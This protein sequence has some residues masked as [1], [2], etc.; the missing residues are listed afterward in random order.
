MAQAR[1]RIF[2]FWALATLFLLGGLPASQPAYAFDR[3]GWS[4]VSREEIED[5][6]RTL[7]RA[8]LLDADQIDGLVGSITGQAILT[9]RQ[10]AG[11]PGGYEPLSP[12][13]RAL[14]EAYADGR[15][16]MGLPFGKVQPSR[17]ELELIRSLVR[18][19][20]ASPKE[21]Q[22][23][24]RPVAAGNL[25]PVPCDIDLDLLAQD[26]KAVLVLDAARVGQDG[27]DTLREIDWIPVKRSGRIGPGTLMSAIQ[28]DTDADLDNLRSAIRLAMGEFAKYVF[29]E[30][31]LE[32]MFPNRHLY[33]TETPPGPCRFNEVMAFWPRGLHDFAEDQLS[34]G[35][36]V[37]LND[38]TERANAAE[39][40]NERAAAAL[41]TAGTVRGDIEAAL[42]SYLV[43]SDVTQ[44]RPRALG[45]RAYLSAVVVSE[46]WFD[47]DAMTEAELA[48]RELEAV[49][50]YLSRAFADGRLF[51]DLGVPQPLQEGLRTGEFGVEVFR[52]AAALR[53]Q[54]AGADVPFAAA[55]CGAAAPD[56]GSRS[57]RRRVVGSYQIALVP[58]GGLPIAEQEFCDT[59]ARAE[60]LRFSDNAAA[61]ALCALAWSERRARRGERPRLTRPRF[62]AAAEPLGVPRRRL[63][64][65]LCRM[66]AHNAKIRDRLVQAISQELK[67]SACPFTRGPVSADLC[68]SEE[69]G[70]LVQRLASL[71]EL[72]ALSDELLGIA[73]QADAILDLSVKA[74][75]RRTAAGDHSLQ[76]LCDRGSGALADLCGLFDSVKVTLES[77]RADAAARLRDVEATK[78]KIIFARVDIVSENPDDVQ[79]RLNDKM[80]TALA[81]QLAAAGSDIPPDLYRA[82]SLSHI[83]VWPPVA[84]D[85]FT[86]DAGTWTIYG[87]MAGLEV[88]FC[89]ER[90]DNYGRCGPKEVGPGAATRPPEPRVRF[91]PHNLNERG[92]FGQG[93]LSADAPAPPEQ[94]CVC[95]IPSVRRPPENSIGSGGSVFPKPG[96]V[97]PKDSVPVSVD[98]DDPLSNGTAIA[99]TPD[100]PTPDALPMLGRPGVGSAS[101]AATIGGPTL[102][103][104]GPE[105][106]IA[107]LQ[108]PGKPVAPQVTERT[109]EGILVTGSSGAFRL[110]TESD[111]PHCIDG[112]APLLL[113]PDVRRQMLSGAQDCARLI[114]AL[115][116]ADGAARRWAR[117]IELSDGFVWLSAT[118][119]A[120]E[121]PPAR[122]ACTL[123]DGGLRGFVPHGKGYCGYLAVI[124]D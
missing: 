63:V 101:D 85:R 65:Q 9:L 55:G 43:R 114:D 82:A 24:E 39:A 14:L 124:E 40:A 32:L 59:G 93:T 34:Y 23:A 84:V 20:Q 73:E 53:H 21:P 68:W 122:A 18:Q 76:A 112:D 61:R 11:L 74:T 92:R 41:E 44:K 16:S 120:S 88:E 81:G 51:D 30:F 106:S 79:E 104:I 115:K 77:A 100:L 89:T 52:D 119:G 70:R 75:D 7:S 28:A 57:R 62:I 99:S 123:E 1:T 6:Q 103:P 60:V 4:S 36:P 107:A 31:D 117:R 2:A 46:M 33:A 91:D 25:G 98:P 83:Y 69:L 12:E 58:S 3:T 118:R 56:S 48:R 27:L 19:A 102:T 17:R 67:V 90:G 109:L 105:I 113:E 54:G 50:D 26:P 10:Y 45:R 97:D 72:S 71:D 64:N 15:E 5:M 22:A 87:Q 80:L 96:P 29:N 66:Q 121:G 95:D 86:R 38:W 78:S 35:A 47:P 37:R 111:R 42:A 8:G 108:P 49:A 110:K 94:A 13:E 116:G